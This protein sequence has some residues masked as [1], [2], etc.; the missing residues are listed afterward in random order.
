MHV[1]SNFNV[2]IIE[3]QELRKGKE[4]MIV[5]LFIALFIS[6]LAFLGM[7]VGGITTS[8]FKRNLPGNIHRLY[9]FCGGLLAGLL[10]FEIIPESIEQYDQMGLI[11]GGFLGLFT[12][13][14]IETIFHSKI[15][16][17]GKRK[18]YIHGIIF[19]FIAIAIHNIPTG[20]A[21]GSNIVDQ[22]ITGSPLLLALFLHQIPEGITLMVSSLLAGSNSLSFTLISALLAIVL[23]ISVIGGMSISNLS[24]Q[25]NTII[26]GS[27]VGTLGYV[28]VHEILWK[29][30]RTVTAKEYLV[31]VCLGL[32]FI[33]LYVL[34]LELL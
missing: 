8:Y 34:S 6:F 22:S 24:H 14:S 21:I 29:T 16:H 11:I 12:M 1:F 28:T 10:V 23:G 15:N 33:R 18:N 5:N 2:Y 17:K 30:K 4:F 31:L 19:L 27:A 7:Y 32:T 26:M 3:Q 20:F 13:M 25:F 9:I